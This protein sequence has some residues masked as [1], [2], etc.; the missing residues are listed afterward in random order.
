MLVE[1]SFDTLHLLGLYSLKLPH[2]TCPAGKYPSK[3]ASHPPYLAGSF[4]GDQSPPRVT[5]VMPHPAGS[6]GQDWNT[7]KVTP[8]PVMGEW[9]RGSP[10]HQHTH[11]SCG[12]VSH[13][14][15]LGANCTHQPA[16]IIYSWAS[17]PAIL[18][19]ALPSSVPTVLTA[20]HCNQL[21]WKWALLISIAI[22][23][24]CTQPT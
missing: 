4:S 23:G 12:L 24:G 21:H 13:Q 17:Q 10:D 8:T 2:P 5:T 1:G 3:G 11:N 9:G 15:A 16:H 14:A 7:S 20:G 19:P 18:G 22:T 6:P